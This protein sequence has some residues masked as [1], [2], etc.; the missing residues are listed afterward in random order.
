[1][2]NEEFILPLGAEQESVDDEQNQNDENTLEERLSNF[3]QQWKN[4]LTSSASVANKPR[5]LSAAGRIRNSPAREKST[6]LKEDVNANQEEKAK[7][8]FMEGVI[9]ERKGQ[10]YEAIQYYRHAIQLVPDIESRISDFSSSN[11]ASSSEPSVNGD[12]DE[13]EELE[14]LT[15]QLSTLTTDTIKHH[16][17]PLYPQKE[18]HISALPVELL[19]ILFRWVVSS[20]LDLRSLEQLSM[21]CRGFYV[22]AR[23]PELWR[24]SCLKIYGKSCILTKEYLSWRHMYLHRPHLQFNGVYI[25][26]TSY[27]RQGEPSM[28]N[29]YRPWHLVE[30]YRYI[31]VFS[32]GTMLIYNSPDEPQNVLAKLKYKTSPLPGI[33]VGRYRLVSDLVTAVL[34]KENMKEYDP[35]LHRYTRRKHRISMALP[36]SEQTFHVELGICSGINR[37]NLKLEFKHYSC[38]TRYRTT[39]NSNITEFDVDHFAPLYFSRVKSYNSASS[40]PL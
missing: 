3:R 13:D 27:Y 39:G 2:E 25:S 6:G 18:T 22:C 17:E 24:E 32:D 16:S 28:D 35:I 8:L 38:H 11:T 1:M 14:D 30:Y 34:H 15:A 20:D 26:K 9:S 36:E 37:I 19:L 31:R 10:M 21:V 5:V 7:C 33:M 4:E 23:D 12:D 40:M 29:L